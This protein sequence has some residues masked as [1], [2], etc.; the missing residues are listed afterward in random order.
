MYTVLG[1]LE[2]VLAFSKLETI[3]YW[4]YISNIPLNQCW[5]PWGRAWEWPKYCIF[6]MV[7]VLGHYFWIEG[8]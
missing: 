2:K 3:Q 4:I 1:S 6:I 8:I 5:V 7:W